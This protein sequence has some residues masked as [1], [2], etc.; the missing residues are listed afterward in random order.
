MMEVVLSRVG[1]V[2]ERLSESLGVAQM[3]QMGLEEET[4]TLVRIGG[5]GTVICKKKK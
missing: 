5:S 4:D 2:K 1:E 3:F